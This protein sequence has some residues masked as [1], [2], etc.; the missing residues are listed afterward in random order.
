[1]KI[2]WPSFDFKNIKRV[3]IGFLTTLGAIVFFSFF[4]G[5]II[6]GLTDNRSPP[7]PKH[8]VLSLDLNG[9]FAEKAGLP[10]LSNPF[11]K[12]MATIHQI[13]RTLDRAADD[14]RV[15][16]LYIK[17]DNGDYGLAHI[18]EFRDA[19]DRFQA[20]G[21][22]VYLYSN[23]FGGFGSSMGEYHLAATMDEIWMQP[24]G[25]LGLTGYSLQMPFFRGLLDKI[26]VEP[27]VI[28]KGR[29]KSTPE[30]FS[31]TTASP[32]NKEMSQALLNS[33]FDQF[34]ADVSA[35]RDID[36]ETLKGI[37]N[38]SP[39]TDIEA[40]KS[41]LIDS[42][43]YWDEFI[44]HVQDGA[45]QDAESV[46]LSRYGRSLGKRSRKAPKFAF[47]QAAGAI[48]SFAEG[49]V[50]LDDD[51]A[52]SEEIW[53]AFQDAMDHPDIDAII[54]RVDSPGG[55][56]T[57]AETIRRAVT[58][59]KKEK[60]V[61]VSMGNMATSG[62]YWVSSEASAIIAQPATLTGSIG[63][64]AIKPNLSGLWEKLNINWETIDRGQNADLWSTNK[65]LTPQEKQQLQSLINHTY[66]QF[67]ERV[68]T[69]RN[70]SPDQLKAVA[71]GRIW[72]GE[73][74]LDNGLID[75]LGGIETTVMKGK[76]LTNTPEDVDVTLIPFPKPLTT[77][78]QII[79]LANEG[80]VGLPAFFKISARIDQA[81]N[82]LKTQDFQPFLR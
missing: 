63:V 69:G 67:L 27:E 72:T 70:L 47:I 6:G 19:I 60:P 11:P 39:M 49:A 65:A 64:F 79:K 1:M 55:T 58:L 33:L 40:L 82:T 24:V 15:H 13:T 5:I 62:G 38:Q 76:E 34:I 20:S 77:I 2:T 73:Q 30:T 7:L 28:S 50:P 35:D 42:L 3:F 61:I 41:G 59:A 80:F 32:A 18:Q 26:G 68:G 29:Y 36:P 43:G 16:G 54:F 81:L 45:P 48:S 56:P 71:E 74:A 66:G 37:I 46:T 21:K 57:A 12:P 53:D 9:S 10:S 14:K 78:E 22:F 8:I 17:L 75:G 4:A 31:Q 44:E 23:S 51:S 25:T 52:F